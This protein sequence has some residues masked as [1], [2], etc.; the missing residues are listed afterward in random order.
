MPTDGL[1]LGYLIQFLSQSLWADG[2]KVRGRDTKPRKKTEALGK[3]M[4]SLLLLSE[5]V[6]YVASG[7]ALTH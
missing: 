2:P 3:A 6:T 7:L 5:V 4:L 1:G